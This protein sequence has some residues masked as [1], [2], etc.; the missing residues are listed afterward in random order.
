M[1]EDIPY[2]FEMCK[3][4]FAGEYEKIDYKKGEEIVDILLMRLAAA[5]MSVKLRLEELSKLS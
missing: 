2:W 1:Q 3:L 4:L 5:E